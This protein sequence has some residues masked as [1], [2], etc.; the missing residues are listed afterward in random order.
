M[1]LNANETECTILRKN[2]ADQ[3]LRLNTAKIVI[4]GKETAKIRQK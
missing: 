3:E 1:K 4:N 2:E